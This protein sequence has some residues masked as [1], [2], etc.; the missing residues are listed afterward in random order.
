MRKWEDFDRFNEVEKKY[1]PVQG[2]GETMATQ[3]VTATTKLIYKWFNDG[4]VYDN[5]NSPM[6]GWCN[7]LSSYAN[8]LA[9]HVNGAETILAKIFKCY[10]ESEYTEILYALAVVVYNAEKLE[11]MNQL[12][13][14]G[15]IYKCDGVFE[16]NDNP[17]EDED[18]D[19][20][21][22]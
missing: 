18:D 19:E 2:E 13:K 5:V 21:D 4:D 15:S 11:K 22:W 1:L 8:W 9:T 14:I 20:D 12:E 16:F 7:D 6:D 17:Y 10:S 3:A